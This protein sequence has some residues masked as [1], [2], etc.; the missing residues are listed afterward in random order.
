MNNNIGNP[1]Y[2]ITSDD[3]DKIYYYDILNKSIYYVE[4]FNIKNRYICNDKKIY[5]IYAIILN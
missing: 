1:F 3:T 4:N 5:E 2:Y